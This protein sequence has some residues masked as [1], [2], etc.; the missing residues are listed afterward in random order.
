MKTIVFILTLLLAPAVLASGNNNTDIRVGVTSPT[1]LNSTVKERGD[2]VGVAP[3]TADSGQAGVTGGSK[4]GFLGWT[5][6]SKDVRQMRQSDYLGVHYGTHA[7]I[8]HD[9][10]YRKFKRTLEA[11]GYNC[12][13]Y[14]NPEVPFAPAPR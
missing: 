1:Y 8:A 12:D 9:C 5:W 6:T 7:R 4:N 3:W 2:V 13:I 10:R 14:Y 11:A